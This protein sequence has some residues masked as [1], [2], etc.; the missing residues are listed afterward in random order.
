MFLE[1]Y[2]DKVSPH[3]KFDTDKPAEATTQAPEHHEE[4]TEEHNHEDH[5]HGDEE[6]D[7]E[8]EEAHEESHYEPPKTS[9]DK[10]K[11]DEQTSA[12][13]DE[14]SKAKNA[15]YDADREFNSIS[16]EI[17]NAKR[18]LEYDV[19]PNEEF[20]SMIDTCFEFEDREYI[21][22]LCPFDKTVQKSKSGNGETSIGSWSSWATDG[23]K[24][25]QMIFLNGLTCWN[26]PARSTKVHLACGSENKVTSV[27]EPNRCEYEMRFETPA[28]CEFSDATVSNYSHTEL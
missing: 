17:S 6:H 5:E 13:L 7:H 25:K 14:A 8:H 10:P 3:L 22:K 16:N 9:G 26:G 21:Y 12:L 11:Y 19:G 15:F 20:A 18:K 1:M 27:S 23:D 2:Y 4:A 24:Y 28:A